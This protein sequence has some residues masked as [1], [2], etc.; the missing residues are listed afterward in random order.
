MG[1]NLATLKQPDTQPDSAAM[2]TAQLE[3]DRTTRHQVM[4]SLIGIQFAV[5][6]IMGL[7]LNDN[8]RQLDDKL[9]SVAADDATNKVLLHEI[10]N[11]QMRRTKLVYNHVSNP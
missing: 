5:I 3:A 2:L 9:A 7:F 6:C 10:H 1:N 4:Y 11:E 8:H